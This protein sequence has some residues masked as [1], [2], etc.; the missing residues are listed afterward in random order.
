VE[1]PRD[2]QDEVARGPMGCSNPLFRVSMKAR[3]AGLWV[4]FFAGVASLRLAWAE[5]TREK[6]TP[7]IDLGQMAREY[8]PLVVMHPDERYGLGNV[9]HF[10]SRFQLVLSTPFKDY[11]F[12]VD[13]NTIDKVVHRG[14]FRTHTTTH[15]K[16]KDNWSFESRDGC[17]WSTRSEACDLTYLRAKDPVKR[18]ARSVVPEVY[19]RAKER[20][21]GGKVYVVLQYF[22][23]LMLNDAQ[24]KHD[25]E[26]ESSIV[27]VD[28]TA[29]SSAGPSGLARRRAI[30]QIL[31][32]GHY[33]YEAF[34][35]DVLARHQ[36]RIFVENSSHYVHVMSLGGHGAYL[37]VPQSGMHEA[38]LK[39][40]EYIGASQ[41]RYATWQAPVRLVRVDASTPWIRYV[42]RWGRR[43]GSL[44]ILPMKLRFSWKPVGVC[45][46]KLGL[47]WLKSRFQVIGSAPYGPKYLHQ[48]AWYWENFPETPGPTP[49]RWR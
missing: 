46:G 25:G 14:W 17:E 27:V 20:S 40:F 7:E 8:A 33:R 43:Y 26:W 36:D 13:E 47:G 6:A 29:Y 44:D 12:D 38:S 49:R 2:A 16:W 37:F 15:P 9:G 48:K 34:D 32:A 4:L 10:F 5:E 11:R 1:K 28:R 3:R 21:H 30:S 19:W 24:N 22:F 45:K 41:K 18:Y 42:G 39:C 23:L 31:T 35:Q